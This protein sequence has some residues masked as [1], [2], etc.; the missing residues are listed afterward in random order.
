VSTTKSPVN[1]PKPAAASPAALGTPA[2]AS[3]PSRSATVLA[4]QAQALAHA[5]FDAAAAAVVNQLVLSLS[6]ERVSLGLYTGGRLRVVAVSGASDVRES[7]AAVARLSAAMAEALDQRLVIVHP[8]P[9]GASP[10]ITLAHQELSQH[11]GQAAVCTV[12]VATR[13][14]MLGALLF[15]RRGGFDTGALEIAKDAAMFAGPLLAY[16]QR[17]SDGLGL[18]VAQALRPGAPQP[19]SAHRRPLWQ[20]AAG[21]AALMLGAAAL[22]PVTHHVVAPTKPSTGA[23]MTCW[24]VPS[25]R[26]SSRW[27]ATSGPQKSRSSISST[28]RHCPRTRPRRR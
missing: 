24:T 26:A 5:S 15:E 28:A 10:A 17:A 20:A 1:V 4:L 7:H 11:S 8:L 12:P 6:C 21:A 18:R 2:R 27:S 25:T 19:F 9:S 14:E 22:W 23:A 3:R 16:Q 13:H